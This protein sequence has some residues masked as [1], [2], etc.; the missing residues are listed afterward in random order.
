LRRGLANHGI[1]VYE[2]QP[3]IIETA[4]TAP[5]QAHYDAQIARGL[6]AIRRWG[7]PQDVARVVATLASG[8]LPFTVGQ[9]ITVDG[10]LLMPRF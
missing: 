5:A 7:T 3:G 2:V 1:G 9:T 8:E 4:M 6:T 10:G